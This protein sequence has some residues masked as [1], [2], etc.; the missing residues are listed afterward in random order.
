MC[1][2][3][4]VLLCVYAFASYLCDGCNN[5]SACVFQRDWDSVVPIGQCQTALTLSG[6]HQRNV[7]L[8]SIFP[9][10]ACTIKSAC[11]E[12]W[13][14]LY[15]DS[16]CKI[17]Q[18][19][20]DG[21]KCQPVER[22]KEHFTY[23]PLKQFP[24]LLNCITPW[25]SLPPCWINCATPWS[26]FPPCWINCITPWSSFPPCWINCATPWSSAQTTCS[27]RHS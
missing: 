4:V 17:N 11:R 27:Q 24:T 2:I 20:S 10:Y 21:Q 15:F 16:W 22:K 7:Q 9:A 23:V 19:F 5:V 3:C 18:S 13:I 8:G 26:S 6:T 1:H 12:N 25:S 14:K